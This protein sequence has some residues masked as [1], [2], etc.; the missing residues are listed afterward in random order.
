MHIPSVMGNNPGA[1]IAIVHVAALCPRIAGA[2]LST[3][4]QDEDRLQDVSPGRRVDTIIANLTVE[5]PVTNAILEYA[6]LKIDKADAV[7][8]LGTLLPTS[9]E[10]DTQ[11]TQQAIRQEQPGRVIHYGCL[12]I[13][14][15]MTSVRSIK[16]NFKKFRKSFVHIGD[17]FIFYVFQR[18]GSASN[19]YNVEFRYTAHG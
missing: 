14:P 9:V 1:N 4:I 3:N 17:F 8:A 11:G 19:S 7:P 15:G 12:P 5:A 16:G 2:S 6:W 13:T 18:G 10:C